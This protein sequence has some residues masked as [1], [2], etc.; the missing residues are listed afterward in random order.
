M[1]HITRRNAIGSALTAALCGSALTA[2]AQAATPGASKAPRATN[3]HF[4]AGFL[5]GA[6]TAGHQV[7]GQ[8]TNSDIWLLE[9]TKP[10]IYKESSG[11]ACDSFNRWPQ[12]LD[13]VRHLGLNT[14]RFS[15]EWSRIEPAQGEFS[16][17]MLDHYKRMITGCRDRGITPVV[18]FNHYSVPI[19]FAAAGGW[20]SAG[21]VD[22]FAR[23]CD[24]AARHLSAEIGLATTLNE[25][26]ILDALNWL[27]LP[28]PPEMKQVQASML[29]N[30]ARSCGTALFSSS[31]AGNIDA[32]R[33]N[34]LAGHR[35]GY[36]AIKAANPSLQ[37]GVS[38]TVGD[39]Q[40]TGSTTARDRKREAVYGP[41][42]RLIAEVGDFIGVQNYGRY[43]FDDHGP[44]KPPAGAELTQMGEEFY[45]ASLEGAVR[46]AHAATGKPVLISENGIATTDDSRRAAYIPQAIAGVRR[47]IASGVPVMGYIHWS[48]MDNFEW[49]FGFEPRYGL[50]AVDRETFE[51]TPKPS[52]Y[53]YGEI[54]QGKRMV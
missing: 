24:K 41:W 15:L 17:V 7:E 53:V 45:P 39:D 21:S 29:A 40:A 46:Y 48:L 10:S 50:T 33:G 14:Y 35:A 6:A 2:P 43:L 28:F 16:A 49:L 30:A 26:N 32:M 42:M 25:P 47:A 19:W 22:H 34:L 37:V 12:D 3:P 1:T 5:W 44:I 36:H 9:H 20:E 31:N 52:A 54:A 13:L 4:P 8:N 23:Y 38:L 11:D 51:R 27:P 18:T